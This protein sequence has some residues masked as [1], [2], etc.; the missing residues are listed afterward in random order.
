MKRL[1]F[2]AIA[3][4]ALSGAAV[5]FAQPPSAVRAACAAD[6]AQ[7]CPNAQPGNGSIRQC[8]MSH[9]SDLSTGC[10]QAIAAAMAAR[11]QAGAT[12][13]APHN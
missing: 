10:K 13:G 8:M 4:I 9:Q 1:A 12:S 7:L 5:S 6:I 11:Q 3:A 2:L